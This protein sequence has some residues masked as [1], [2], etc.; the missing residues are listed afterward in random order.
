MKAHLVRRAE[1]HPERLAGMILT[2]DVRG[3]GGERTFAKGRVIRDDD[4]AALLALEWDELHVIE[5]EPGE[6][7]EDEAGSRIATAIAGDGTT[8]GTL[9]GGHWPV[10]ATRRGL[11][12]V[13]VERLARMNA[14]EGA[15]VYTLYDGQIVEAGEVVARAKITP[16]VIDETRIEMVE[17]IARDSD[18]VVRV[19]AFQPMVVGAVVQETLG[20]RAMARFREALAEKVTWFGSRLLEPR[21]VAPSDA[22]VASAVEDA[23][24]C[25]ARVIVMAGTKAMDPLDPAFLA[26]ERLGVRLERYGL[27]AHPGSLFWMAQLGDIPLLGMP[28]CGLFSQATVFD[29]VLP[30]VLAGERVGRDELSAL[31]HGGLLTRD[32]AFRFPRYRAAVGR[33]EL[34]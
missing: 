13:D 14:I 10:A 23:A 26:L 19:S 24:A 30:R 20:E 12:R 7:H 1:A 33:G 31:G 18:G 34:E 25:G 28:S 32:V 22:E 6:I 15:C 5:A 17:R 27:P 11:L 3:S 4:V 29:L 9:A 8:A 21:F 2:R 16:F